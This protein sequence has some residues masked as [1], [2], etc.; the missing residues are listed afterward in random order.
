MTDIRAMFSGALGYMD[1]QARNCDRC[2]LV[3]TCQL[4][5]AADYAALGARDGILDDM[6]VL[7]GWDGQR[8]GQ[9]TVFEEEH[10]E[11]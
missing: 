3:G 4:L 10:D 6:A 11:R 8:M 2:R 5:E 7:M 9:C 1:W